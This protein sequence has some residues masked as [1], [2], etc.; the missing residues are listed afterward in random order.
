MRSEFALLTGALIMGA[1]VGLSRC[2][3]IAGIR[4]PGL[5]TGTGLTEGFRPC[6]I[7][8][9]WPADPSYPPAIPH[10]PYENEESPENY[11]EKLMNAKRSIFYLN[12]RS[13]KMSLQV[14]GIYTQ[15]E[16]IFF[17]LRFYNHSHI[18]YAVDSIRFFM[19]DEKQLTKTHAEGSTLSPVYHCGN[20]GLIKGKSGERCVFALSRFTL[21]A[22]KRLVI[23]VLEKNGGRRLR[24]FTDNYTLVKARLI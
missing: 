7:L 18:D 6:R 19:V 10:P 24:L 2:P 23:E 20:A 5:F 21:A 14:R 11:C 12:T 9:P 13:Y 22:G 3:A 15:G 8:P 17:C 16:A 1:S 4:P